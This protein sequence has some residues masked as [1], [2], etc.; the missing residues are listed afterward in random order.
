MRLE[1]KSIEVSNFLSFGKVPQ[2]MEFLPGINVVTGLDDKTKRSNGS[3]KSSWL[4]SIPYA[5]FG[6]INKSIKKENI[7]NWK[8]KKNCWVEFKFSKGTDEYTI[9]RG[10]KPDHLEISHNGR[11]IPQSSDVRLFQKMLEEEILGFDY[12]NFMGLSYINMNSYIPI[13]KMDSGK[14]RLFLEKTFGLQAFSILNDKST[15]KLKV[16]EDLIY[17]QK[18]TAETKQKIIADL[19][20]NNDTLKEQSLKLGSSSI[21]L[22]DVLI[23][24]NELIAEHKNSEKELSDINDEIDNVKNVLVTLR[25]NYEILKKEELTRFF[26]ILDTKETTIDATIKEI[27]V[28]TSIVSKRGI[29][30]SERVNALNKNHELIDGKTE[31][32]T[33]GAE[34]NRAHDIEYKNELIELNEKLRVD[35]LEL[36][37]L[38]QKFVA[39]KLEKDSIAKKRKQLTLNGIESEKMKVLKEEINHTVVKQNMLQESLADMKEIVSRITA[40]K[41]KIDLLEDQVKRETDTRDGLQSIISG[42][43]VKITDLQ[44]E[45]TEIVSSVKRLSGITDYLS[46]IKFLCHDDNIKTY[47]I[48]SIIPYLTKQ[49]NHY[50]SD[51]GSQFYARFDNWLDETIEGPGIYGCSYGNLSGAESK[52]I[53]LALQFAFLDVAR[54][55]A[56][57]FPDILILDELLDSSVDS[58]GLNNLL[59]IIRAR[60]K[61]DNAKV[62]LITHRSEI[63]DLESD[64]VYCIEKREGYSYLKTL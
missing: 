47:V 49:T 54:I 18:L 13:L 43:E 44:N 39:A 17:K 9:H 28:E 52:S 24:Y 61:D 25:N 46:Y 23:R 56:G 8:N 60:Q 2:K 3:G 34:I 30:N 41:H 31:C 63:A 7:I 19:L 62:F 35:N 29:I 11:S 40:M 55:Q 33:C 50:L 6:R 21:E 58:V 51:A 22:K 27:S 37:E 57:V 32:P 53:D 16:T 42:N 26:D 36:V 1:A 59:D 45:H 38:N 15:K 14:K 10:I 5:L 20:A 12:F 64:H 4:E 48:S